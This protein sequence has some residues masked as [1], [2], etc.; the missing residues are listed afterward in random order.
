MNKLLTAS[1]EEKAKIFRQVAMR[2]NILPAIIEKDFWVCHILYLLFSSAEMKSNL[3]FKGGTSLSKV[4]NV[5]NRF[6]EDVDLIL[7]WNLLEMEEP[8][9]ERSKSKQNVFNKR[10]NAKAELY[11]RNELTPL[12]NRL[13]PECSALYTDDDPATI[14]IRYP[15][16]VEGSYILPYIRLELGPLA[17]WAPNSEYPIYSYVS[18]LFPDLFEKEPIL[19]KALDIERT[20]WEKAT[21][22]HHEANRPAES[23]MPIRYSRH[24][25]DLYMLSANNIFKNKALTRADIL[26]NVAAFKNRFYPRNWAQY[27]MAKV[28]TIKIIPPEY[29]YKFLESD[30]KKMQE[31]IYGKVPDFQQIMSSLKALENEIRLMERSR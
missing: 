20:F 15:M 17:A 23:S 21:I 3:I 26:D 6:S 8:Y 2:K 25:Y 13:M 28:A 9:L 19:V 31:M 1:A 22:L 24:Y 29:R 12:I 5:I 11:I 30:Y 7:N 27:D 14:Q 18:E 10:M 4:F 16:S